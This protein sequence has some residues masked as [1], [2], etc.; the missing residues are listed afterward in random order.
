MTANGRYAEKVEYDLHGFVGIQLVNALPG[1]VKIVA[2]QLGPIRKS[3]AREPDIVIRFVERLSN[4][5]RV[6]YVGLNE[7]GFTNDA[8][9]VLRSDHKSR[10]VVQIPFDQIGKKCEIVCE[11]G[12]VAIPLLIAIINLTALGKG[13]L[14]MHASAFTYKGVGVLATGWAKGGKT[15]MLLAFMNQ[16]AHYVGDEWVYL[17]RDGECMFGIPE[18][19]RLWDWHLQEM[20]VYRSK[21]GRGDQARLHALGLIL[22]TVDGSTRSSMA[23]GSA[24]VNL[25]RRVTPILRRQLYVHFPPEQ[26]FGKEYCTLEGTPDVIF[27]L[28][29]HDSDEIVVETVE[30]EEIANRM[31]FSLQH[32]RADFLSYYSR[33]R[34]A[35]PSAS[36]ILIDQVG[37][38]EKELL[39]SVLAG[40]K[41]YAVYHPYPVAIPSLY[42]AT[43]SLLSDFR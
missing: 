27:F 1:D 22:K 3:L 23:K 40:K 41:S 24:P 31:V 7:A 30:S 6:R 28:A 19:I 25:M 13:L 4:S 21:V 12:L 29:S 35:F 32:E 16:G 38:L 39:S 5:S 43:N 2:R 42:T 20:P 11:R 33:F 14:P 17:T 10:A 9:L 34:F 37:S 8:F 18:P 36:S 15:E 26:L